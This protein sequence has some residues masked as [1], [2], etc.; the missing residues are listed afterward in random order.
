MICLFIMIDLIKKIAK[1]HDCI[2]RFENGKL[3]DY[4][5]K[6]FVSKINWLNV[7]CNKEILTEEFIKEFQNKIS[8][9]AVSSYQVLSEDFIREFQDKVDWD[10]ISFSQDLSESFIVEFK[11]EL[12]WECIS[13]FQKLSEDF[14]INFANKIYWKKLGENYNISEECKRKFKKAIRLA[15]NQ[16][17]RM[18]NSLIEEIVTIANEINVGIFFDSNNKIESDSLST[19]INHLDWQ[20]TCEEKVLS[21]DFIREFQNELD[22][23]AVSSSQKLSESFFEEFKD[24]MNWEYIS[25]SQKLSEGFIKKFK[26]KLNWTIINSNQIL[27]ENF[28]REFQDEVNWSTISS[29]QKLSEEFIKEFKNKVNWVNISFKQKLS[30]D[31][32]REFQDEIDFTMLHSIISDDFHQEMTNKISQVDSKPEGKSMDE[33][34]ILSNNIEAVRKKYGPEVL[35]LI[36]E[37]IEDLPECDTSAEYKEEYLLIYDTIDT[38]AKKSTIS[39]K[40]SKEV[41]SLLNKLNND[42][43]SNWMVT[44]QDFE[45]WENSKSK[46]TVEDSSQGAEEEEE[47]VGPVVKESRVKYGEFIFKKPIILKELKQHSDSLQT[48]KEVEAEAEPVAEKNFDTRN[49]K[50]W[51]DMTKPFCNPEWLNT[52]KPMTNNEHKIHLAKKSGNIIKDC[53]KHGVAIGAAT[54]GANYVFKLLSKQLNLSEEALNNPVKRELL[55][56]LTVAALHM[57]STIFKDKIP[58]MDKVQTGCELVIQGKSK[59]NFSAMV[60]H[61]V[62][63]LTNAVQMMDPKS[64]F[65]KMFKEQEKLR[66]ANLKDMQL[67]NEA[68][69]IEVYDEYNNRLLERNA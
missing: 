22:W 19:F 42:P 7:A 25:R 49:I 55:M 56:G 28:I 57:G 39:Y 48:E 62:P 43:N 38:L 8:W 21:E 35:L 9:W 69:E 54:E 33:E 65:E 61:L 18:K 3:T 4:S 5:R 11:Y 16:E 51:V 59:D 46:P 1:D 68:E 36:K 37:S 24:K 6:E 58:N 63:V 60:Q 32:M 52:T 26:D 20:K 41:F 45:D 40:E 15:I 29:Y 23:D 31:F 34:M 66:I 50:G 44:L 53:V 64:A 30:E 10:I 47:L 13:Q 17:K 12:D 67:T 14:I 27:S 2:V